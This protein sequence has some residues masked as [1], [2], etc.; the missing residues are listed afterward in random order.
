V[1][2]SLV[3]GAA[4]GYG[5]LLAPPA[6]RQ[7]TG[8]GE[9]NPAVVTI[10]PAGLTTLE[11]ADVDALSEALPETTFSRALLPTPILAS[12]AST[13]APTTVTVQSV[14]PAFFSVYGLRAASGTLFT[15]SD[16]GR[17]SPV[18]VL[19]QQTAR[20]LFG[21]PSAAVGQSLQLRSV[22]F[23]VIG[24]LAPSE[25]PR[26]GRVQPE[27]LCAAADGAGSVVG[28]AGAQRGFVWRRQ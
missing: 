18:A 2:V 28:C 10:A 21:S 12:D 9:S 6:I 20:T 7:L 4:I 3:V 11:P 25:R 24:V 16:D 27:S 26:V 19:G 13:T 22:P 8:R 17:A 5:V 23:T 1:T 14:D 15:S